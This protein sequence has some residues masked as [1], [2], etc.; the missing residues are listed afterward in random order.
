MSKDDDG[1]TGMEIHSIA[2]GPGRTEKERLSPRIDRRS[3]RQRLL[4]A[5]IAVLSLFS[6]GCVIWTCYHYAG[7]W[8][9]KYWSCICSFIASIVISVFETRLLG[10]RSAPGPGPTFEKELSW[11]LLLMVGVAAFAVS[12]AFE[13]GNVIFL[14]IPSVTFVCSF[15]Y[16]DD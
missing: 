12:V 3:L 10:R 7:A 2:S 14:G 15:I 1:M 6:I 4:I 16:Y 11:G 8:F 9:A 5:G 13:P